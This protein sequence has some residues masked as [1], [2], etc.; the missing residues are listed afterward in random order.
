M[1]LLLLAG[2]VTQLGF[3]SQPGQV[4]TGVCSAELVVEAEDAAGNPSATVDP[5]LLVITGPAAIFSAADCTGDP[6][7]V[8]SGLAI[9]AGGTNARFHL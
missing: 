9:P 5:I 7:D 8:S 6:L 3:A 2:A 4:G 1:I